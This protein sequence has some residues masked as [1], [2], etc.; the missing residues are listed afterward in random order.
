[1]SRFRP[2]ELGKCA[3]ALFEVAIVSGCRS[4]PPPPAADVDARASV[5]PPSSP[6]GPVDMRASASDLGQT[7]EFSAIR[8]ACVGYA[9]ARRYF[10]GR[11][12]RDAAFGVEVETSYRDPVAADHALSRGET[13]SLFIGDRA[14]NDGEISSAGVVRWTFYIAEG[15]QPHGP[16][17]YGYRTAPRDLGISFAGCPPH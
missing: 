7:A 14:A 11:A 15:D 16:L 13:P 6:Q 8:A 3:L 2:L 9:P 12:Q 4:P 5:A 10:E 17:R 1:M